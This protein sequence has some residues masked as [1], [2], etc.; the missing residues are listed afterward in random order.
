MKNYSKGFILVAILTSFIWISCSSPEA[1]LVGV[2]IAEDVQIEADQN[3]FSQQQI[4]AAKEMSKSYHFEFF[5]DKTIKIVSGEDAF[6][7][8]W[9]L[10][11]KSNDIYVK[12]EGGNT[13]DS[14]KIG[15]FEDGK[16]I[17][18]DKAPAGWLTVTYKKQ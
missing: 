18:R 12:L 11:A 5:E 7:G 9:N 14:T 4:D 15:Q 16:I 13:N 8:K 2:W 3:K 10:D 1:K 17:S 6:P